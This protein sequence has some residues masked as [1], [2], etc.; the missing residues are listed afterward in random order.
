MIKIN[1]FYKVVINRTA[2]SNFTRMRKYGPNKEDF[3]FNNYFCPFI[4]RK[5]IFK[6]HTHV[7]SLNSSYHRTY[8]NDSS[9]LALTCRDKL[10]RTTLANLQLQNI[11]FHLVISNYFRLLS[12]YK[13]LTDTQ[14]NHNRT[15][16]SQ[17]VWIYVYVT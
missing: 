8:R 15:T 12:F 6:K 1:C 16:P 2:I 11:H 9:T 10:M 7:L 3:F 4:Q 5:V 17:W 14:R 13:T